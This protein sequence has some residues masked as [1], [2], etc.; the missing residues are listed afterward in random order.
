MLILSQMPFM[1]HL[2]LITFS[3]CCCYFNLS[4]QNSIVFHATMKTGSVYRQTMQ[5]DMNIVLNYD[6]VSQELKDALKNNP[7]AANT[8]KKM[9]ML[10]ESETRCGKQDAGTGVMPVRMTVTKDTGAMI[11]DA[12]PVGTTF[13]GHISPGKLPIFDSTDMKAGEQT[14]AMLAT[15]KNISGG[16][17]LPDTTLS[18]GQTYTQ[19]I[20]LDLPGGGMNM[21]ML[22]TQVFTLKGFSADTAGFDVKIKGTLDM[23]GASLPITGTAEGEGHIVYDRHADYFTVTQLDTKIM[24]AVNQGGNVMHVVIDVNQLIHCNINK[25]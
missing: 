7:N 11:V 23:G 16:I 8:N 19:V 12:L 24:M 17:V 5:M 1:R 20:P 2:F 15:M 22:M 10:V 18:V 14:Q 6:S 4:A 21:K 9:G 13:Y 25:E 3:F